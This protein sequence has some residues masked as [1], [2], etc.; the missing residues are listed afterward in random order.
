MDRDVEKKSNNNNTTNHL[1][2][3]D[4]INE[5]RKFIYLPK[6]Y[7]TM[8]YILLL[9]LVVILFI[10][11]H[12][13]KS[14]NNKEITYGFAI[15]SKSGTTIG[16]PMDTYISDPDGDKMTFQLENCVPPHD[17]IFS[18]NNETGLISL[19]KEVPKDTKIMKYNLTISA[20]DGKDG[21]KTNVSTIISIFSGTCETC[22]MIVQEI[23]R[24]FDEQFD[25]ARGNDLSLKH[26]YQHTNVTQIIYDICEEKTS[27][28]NS[29]KY[30][31]DCKKIMRHWK[32]VHG[33]FS[34]K[35]LKPNFGEVS[36]KKTYLRQL[37]LCNA[38]FGLCNHVVDYTAHKHIRKSSCKKCLAVAQDLFDENKRWQYKNSVEL[39]I[40]AGKNPSAMTL[41]E[42]RSELK[43]LGKQLNGLRPDLVKRLIESR[44]DNF[45][46]NK[47]GKKTKGKK[48]KTLMGRGK[49]A[50]L[51]ENYCIT[52]PMRH[53]PTMG[54]ILDNKCDELI[55]EYET[56][57]LD[58]LL[59]PSNSNDDEKTAGRKF[60]N[61][62]C[63]TD[64][65]DDCSKKKL[66]NPTNWWRSPW[67]SKDNSYFDEL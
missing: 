21:G 47:K 16:V 6:K 62:L 61:M 60:A 19:S 35:D 27:L 46:N 36:K 41:N 50:T 17:G 54:S 23:H 64:I 24:A 49:L 13:Q 51:L 15:D 53:P 48:K 28:L 12:S 39:S 59:Q 55:E 14:N 11:C 66:K 42:I 9:L 33:T 22:S 5:P 29:K 4:Q 58:L 56:E 31:D 38:T 63:G 20:S 18:L 32:Y 3:S 1:F 25:D 45:D 52:I 7:T 43:S 30:Y 40:K 37:N 44:I 26:V 8:K 2:K 10:T 34:G 65:S 67:Y 57:I